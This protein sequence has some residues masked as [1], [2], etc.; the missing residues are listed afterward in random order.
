M[1]IVVVAVAFLVAGC[2]DDRPTVE[3]TEGDPV[4]ERRPL[5]TDDT[6]ALAMADSIRADT[7]RADSVEVAVED[8]AAAPPPPEFDAFW[9]QFQAA[10]RSGN[11]NAVTRYAK[12]GEEGIGLADIDQAYIKAFSEP[13]R[14]ALLALSP[15]DFERD[16]VAREI[17]VVVGFDENGRVVPEDEAD[18]DES[19]RLRFDV[20]DGRYRW[21][22]FAEER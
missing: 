10:V 12:L 5:V 20:I 1:R 6:S 13:F 22:G 21:V 14:S 9:I 2:G 11:V 17:Q 4:A 3:I 7:L 16:S 18:S 8:S 15:R 19:I